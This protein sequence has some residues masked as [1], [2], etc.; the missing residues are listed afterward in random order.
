MENGEAQCLPPTATYIPYPQIDAWG[1]S[2]NSWSSE[3]QSE[4]QG[5]NLDV[6]GEK[7]H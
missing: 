5:S 3:E 1:N 7:L 4:N 6:F 2:H